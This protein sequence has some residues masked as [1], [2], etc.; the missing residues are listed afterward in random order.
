LVREQ[1]LR[2]CYPELAAYLREKKI[3][4]MVELSEATQRYL[5]A[6]YDKGKDRKREQTRTNN[7]ANQKVHKIEN[8][9]RP[10]CSVCKKGNHK[11]E[12]C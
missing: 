6:M 3:D 5:D 7:V 2:K 10:T 11:E 9:S 4:D 12:D 1:F 8:Q